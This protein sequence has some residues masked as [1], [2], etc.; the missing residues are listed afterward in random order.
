[1]AQAVVSHREDNI[2]F[3]ETVRGGVFGLGHGMLVTGYWMLTRMYRYSVFKEIDSSLFD[4]ILN[5]ICLL[6]T[7]VSEWLNFCL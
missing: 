6:R 3:S 7:F 2:Q 5:F 4:N 1:M